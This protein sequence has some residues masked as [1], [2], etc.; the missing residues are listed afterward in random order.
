MNLKTTNT[1]ADNICCDIVIEIENDL[2]SLTAAEGTDPKASAGVPVCG[3]D[4]TNSPGFVHQ[5]F[6]VGNKVVLYSVYV[7]AFFLSGASGE[8]RNLEILMS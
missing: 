6:E 1:P 4:D 7:S 3:S 8:A 2:S 5:Q